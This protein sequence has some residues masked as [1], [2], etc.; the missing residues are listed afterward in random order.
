MHV[1]VFN[2]SVEFTFK[3]KTIHILQLTSVYV[4]VMRGKGEHL[5]FQRFAYCLMHLVQHYSCNIDNISL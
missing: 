3:M 2:F 4:L 1:L 5:I